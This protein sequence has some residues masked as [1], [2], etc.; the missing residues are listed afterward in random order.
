MTAP[1]NIRSG[2]TSVVDPLLAASTQDVVNRSRAAPFDLRHV[3]GGGPQ[4]AGLRA[5]LLG[6]ASQRVQATPTRRAPI[7]NTAAFNDNAAPSA[8][9]S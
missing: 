2:Y 7:R 1:T 6:P 8:I 9:P 4:Q 3:P 5:E